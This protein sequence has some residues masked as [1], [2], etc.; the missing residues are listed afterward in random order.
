MEAIQYNLAKQAIL[1]AQSITGICKISNKVHG[2]LTFLHNINGSESG[3]M[4]N[5]KEKKCLETF[6]PTAS[7]PLAEQ[8][9]IE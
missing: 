9:F 6:K 4:K 7:Y 3:W 5:E 2:Q 8:Q 1:I